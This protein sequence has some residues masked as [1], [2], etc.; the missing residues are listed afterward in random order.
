MEVGK[1]NQSTMGK[2]RPALK[3]LTSEEISEREKIAHMI[4]A[5][6]RI[7]GKLKA[8]KH[9]IEN[10]LSSAYLYKNASILYKK[11]L[12]NQCTRV[13]YNED[14]YRILLKSELVALNNAMVRAGHEATSTTMLDLNA[15]VYGR[16]AQIH[17]ALGQSSE[18]KEALKKARSAYAEMAKRQKHNL[19]SSPQRMDSHAQIEV[20]IVLI[21]TR[22]RQLE[23][24][25]RN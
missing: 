17:Y 12:E 19:F 13:A 24:S 1:H 9:G 22:L 15:Q 4:A 21:D 7:D 20:K 5:A 10:S 23:K 18:E 25:M 16:S 14:S 11:G 2:L 6:R 8:N 3:S